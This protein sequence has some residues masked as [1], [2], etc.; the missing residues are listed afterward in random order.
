[1]VPGTLCFSSYIHT[2]IHTYLAYVVVGRLTHSTIQRISRILAVVAY[3]TQ[4]SVMCMCV[5]YMLVYVSV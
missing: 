3:T 2:Y 5:C 1:M 4:P